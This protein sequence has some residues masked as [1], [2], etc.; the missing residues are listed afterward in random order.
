MTSTPHSVPGMVMDK[1]VSQITLL[2]ARSMRER[3]CGKGYLRPALA[4]TWPIWCCS[5]CRA[6]GSGSN[7]QPMGCSLPVFTHRLWSTSFIH[8]LTNGLFPLLVNVEPSRALL[9]EASD[10][11]DNN[12]PDHVSIADVQEMLDCVW[13]NALRARSSFGGVLCQILL[14]S[15]RMFIEKYKKN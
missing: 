1:L 7:I 11:R 15:H 8:G 3:A 10:S 6:D 12:C 2:Y 14:F 4:D 9:F 5:I 13:T